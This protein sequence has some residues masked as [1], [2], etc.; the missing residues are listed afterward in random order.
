MPNPAPSSSSNTGVV[1]ATSIAGIL[2]A[3]N[4]TSKDSVCNSLESLGDSGAL[5]AQED[6][7]RASILVRL[8]VTVNSTVKR[9]RADYVSLIC[10]RVP[11]ESH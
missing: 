6:S 2:S 7:N 5:V 11:V 3:D 4:T 9:G 1:K 10:L 8:C